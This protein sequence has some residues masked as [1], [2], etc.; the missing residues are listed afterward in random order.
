MLKSFLRLAP[1]H[2]FAL[3]YASNY[4]LCPYHAPN[5]SEHLL[6]ARGKFAWDQWAVLRLAAALDLDL[7]FNP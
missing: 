2:H 7:I 6:P 4:L 3:F 1:Q 5:V